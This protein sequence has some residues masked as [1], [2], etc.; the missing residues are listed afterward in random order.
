VLKAAGIATHPTDTRVVARVL[1]A[2]RAFL[3]VCVN[4]TA[5]DATRRVTIEGKALDIPVLSGRAR[6]VLVERGT[7]KVLVATPGAPVMPGT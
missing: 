3:A 4:E 2:P 5:E 7:G 1:E 6:L